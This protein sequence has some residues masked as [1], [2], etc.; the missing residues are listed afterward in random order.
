ML[1]LNLTMYRLCSSSEHHV[2]SGCQI[3][4]LQLSHQKPD[5]AG[6]LGVLLRLVT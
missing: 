2:S 6:D 1:I 5:R 4:L 3:V